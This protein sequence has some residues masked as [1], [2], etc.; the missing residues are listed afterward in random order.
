MNKILLLCSAFALLT[1]SAIAEERKLTG[2]EITAA[3]TDT[4]LSAKTDT[5]QIF[6][7]SGVTFYSENGS[8]SQG[9]W[10]V[11]GDQYCSQWP[12]NTAWPCY[13]VLQDGS[14]ITFVSASGNRYEMQ[15][16]KSN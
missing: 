16:P 3:L 5:T 1:S 2:A 9:F 13:D 8:Q 15:L 14:K 10:K 6:Q 11:S 4:V 7:M 12:P